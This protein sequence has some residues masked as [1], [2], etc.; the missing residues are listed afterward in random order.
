MNEPLKL[1]DSITENPCKGKIC[2]HVALST[3]K[4]CSTLSV[5]IEATRVRSDK[6]KMADQPLGNDS[7]LIRCLYVAH[8]QELCTY[9]SRQ[10][11]LDKAEAEDIVQGAFARLTEL[12]N[13]DDIENHRAFLYKM[14][15]NMVLDARR[16][17]QVSHS[18]ALSMTPDDEAFT[19]IGPAEETEVRQRL[20]LIASALWGMPSKRRELLMMNR[21][22]GLSYAEIARR[23]G[24]SETVVRKHVSKALADCHRA[25]N[26]DHE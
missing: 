10:F 18:Y 4:S 12:S 14:C 23:V 21:F 2:R 3:P 17:S 5:T 26:T 24:L 13:L 7:E 19:E 8:K 6:V 22:D 25:L 1:P 16:H 15:G 9:L 11:R 20:G